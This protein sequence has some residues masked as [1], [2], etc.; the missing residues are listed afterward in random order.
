[1]ENTLFYDKKT[2]WDRMSDAEQAAMMEYA[3]GY[4]AFLDEAKTER[5]A[6]RRLQAMAEANGFA[7]YTRGK[8]IHPGEKY[9]KINRNK[10]II[11][12][13]V[14]SDGMH[15]GINLSAAHL[16]A[17][18]IDIRTVPLYEDNGMALFKTHYYGGIKKYQWTTIPMELRGVVCHMT[19]NGVESVDVR[20]GDKPGDP[21]FVIT[22]LLI[23]LATEQMGKTMMKGIEAEN[24]NV[25]V[26][27]KPSKSD[28][29]TSDKIKLWVMEF[30]NKEYG[31]TEE[32]FLSA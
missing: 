4:K 20:I 21:V 6:V 16:D 11:L 9:Y 30:L 28:I 24:M 18:R 19:E 23:H 17:P 10:A 5:D 7:A 2:G 29:E 32:D 27:S 13:V 14:G 12:F 8:E 22:D 3:E 25:L 1:M 15:S 26:G 31:I